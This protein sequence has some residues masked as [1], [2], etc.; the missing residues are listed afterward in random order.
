MA[1]KREQM[2]LDAQ[3]RHGVGHGSRE[4][5]ADLAGSSTAASSG[6]DGVRMGGEVG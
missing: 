1:L 6:I 3:A 5:N 2:Q 4:A